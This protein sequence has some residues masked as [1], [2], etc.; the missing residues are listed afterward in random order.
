MP[1]YIDGIRAFCD[2]GAGRYALIP[3]RLNFDVSNLS[4]HF[5]A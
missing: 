5:H 4:L 1:F 2:F 3:N